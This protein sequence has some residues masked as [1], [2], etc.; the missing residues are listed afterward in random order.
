MEFASTGMDIIQ[1]GFIAGIFWRMGG[2]QTG[3]KNITNR[4]TNLEKTE[5]K[6]L[7]ELT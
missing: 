6:I 1:T 3:L 2:F 5:R 7:N 4:V